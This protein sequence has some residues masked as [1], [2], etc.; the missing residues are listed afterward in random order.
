MTLSKHDQ[1][2]CVSVKEFV[3]VQE[4]KDIFIFDKLIMYFAK[5]HVILIL[6]NILM[7]EF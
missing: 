4:S 7:S 1:E 3:D 6:L 5:L 2:L